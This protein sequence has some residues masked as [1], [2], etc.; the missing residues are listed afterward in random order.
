M[1][2]PIG[3]PN[4]W[5]EESA[6]AHATGC[7]A[8]DSDPRP[9]HGETADVPTACAPPAEDIAVTI[10]APRNQDPAQDAEIA[11]A[12]MS[13]DD[14]MGTEA[15]P[16]QQA[17]EIVTIAAASV[18][19]TTVDFGAPLVHHAVEDLEV[20]PVPDSA[21]AVLDG[22]APSVRGATPRRG[23]YAHCCRW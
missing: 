19:P 6:A 10:N 18:E 21:D 12:P 8:A 14:C 1:L 17:V 11:P 20:A 7:L 23:M 16:I 5:Q 9:A 15:F 4:E 3:T 2:A 22:S 13:D